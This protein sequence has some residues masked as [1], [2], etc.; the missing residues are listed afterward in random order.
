MASQALPPVDGSIPLFPGFVDFHAKH[1]PERPWVVF[2]SFED[3]SKASAITFSELA[4]ATHRI[5]HLAR[6]GREGPE[7]S[8]VGLLINCDNILYVALIHGLLRAG[9]VVSVQL[10]YSSP[11]TDSDVL[12][13]VPIS[14]RNSPEAVANLLLTTHAVRIISQ[15]ALLSLATTAQ[16]Q[17]VEKGYQIAIEN[18]CSIYEVFPTLKSGNKN[19]VPSEGPYPERQTPLDPNKPVIVLHSSGST[20]LPKPVFLTYKIL[21]QWTQSGMSQICHHIRHVYSP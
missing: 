1:N 19:D 3:P 11:W 6:P 18:L 10:A 13:P 5:A 17:L 7:G 8:A 20:G 9:I 16:S 2:P 4:N 15:P 12:Q 14:P 21:L